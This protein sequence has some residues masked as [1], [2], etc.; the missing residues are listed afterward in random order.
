M[1]KRAQFFLI[2]ALVIVG[3]M[4]GL[5]TIYNTAQTSEE[6]TTVYDLSDE[7]NFESSQV[8]DNGIFNGGSKQEE[9]LKHIENLTDFYSAENSRSDLIIIYGDE[10][11][12]TV[13]FYNQ[14]KT[15][16]I[17]INIGGDVSLIQTA[18]PQKFKNETINYP[19]LLNLVSVELGFGIPYEFSLRPGQI[20]YLIIKKE[21]SNERYVS[22]PTSE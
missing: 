21:N 2:A 13:I 1:Q 12:L 6:D 4:F 20:F 9:I 7:I 15:G 17:G 18:Q 19:P 3:I 22:G 11:K 14:T 8:I 10:H 16:S 5:A